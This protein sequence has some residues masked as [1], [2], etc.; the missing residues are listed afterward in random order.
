[1]S[2]GEIQR[3]LRR[4][5]A[6]PETIGP[7]ATD[8][9]TLRFLNCLRDAT[10]NPEQVGPADIAALTSQILRREALLQHNEHLEL[11]VPNPRHAS[12]PDQAQWVSFGLDVLGENK[13]SVRLR[14][15][16]WNPEWLGHD[17]FSADPC[18]LGER[19]APAPST[20]PADPSIVLDLGIRDY[21]SPGQAAA[22]R[23]S[24]LLP[25]GETLVVN[26]PTGSGKSLLFQAAAIRAARRSELTVI[27]VPTTALAKDQEF[28]LR[29]ILARVLPGQSL[30]NLAYHSGLSAEIREDIRQR[31]RQRQQS[32]VITSPE[33]VDQSLRIVI[34]RAANQGW[35]A[36]FALDEAHMLSQWGGYFRP[37]FQL[38]ATYVRHWR[39]LAPQ[40]SR[41]R[42]LLLSATLTDDT[43]ETIRALFEGPPGAEDS[44]PVHVFSVPELRAEPDYFVAEPAEETKRDARVQ[45]A[46]RH[47]PRPMII[48]TTKREPAKQLYTR[49]REA[50]FRRI[51]LFRGGDAATRE[52]EQ[53]LR[54]WR[55]GRL[56][57]VVATSAFG[58]GMDN[59]D[60]RTVVHA[61][62]PE[63]I[64][65]F[66]Q[67]VGR[68]GRDGRA[69]LSLW[70]P[71]YGDE[72]TA[73]SLAK[74]NELII[75]ADI[76]WD[77][78][79]TMR[80]SGEVQGDLS[81]KVELDAVRPSL[82]KKNQENY[83]WNVRVLLLMA[84]AGLIS[85]SVVPWSGVPDDDSTVSEYT[86]EERLEKAFRDTYGYIIVKESGE[87]TRDDWESKTD[88]IRQQTS[89]RLHQSRA[90]VQDLLKGKRP[91]NEVFADTYSLNLDGTVRK[92]A[93]RHERCPATRGKPMLESR[94]GR[95]V[96]S[97][98]LIASLMDNELPD[99]RFLVKGIECIHYPG[100]PGGK[101]EMRT[102][103][104]DMKRCLAYF[105]ARGFVELVL[106]DPWREEMDMQKL[107][108]HCP[109]GFIAVRSLHD[110]QEARKCFD[111]CLPLAR[112]TCL[113]E[114]ATIDDFRECEDESTDQ[115]HIILFPARLADPDRPGHRL[116]EVKQC[117][118]INEVRSNL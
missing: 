37:E 68:G 39:S 33:A 34:E 81:L 97:N 13:K 85:T 117:L 8:P 83:L 70:L 27:I 5:P 76:G 66:Y 102:W 91:F 12:W 52:G 36:C 65:R 18:I 99:S 100:R 14:A 86:D 95:P 26:L 41:L 84:R 46:A 67:E 48:Y 22:I 38:L 63:S 2:F 4:W 109:S 73:R 50:G 69:C 75:S 98:S 55:D 51:A 108:Q 116:L 79:R 43:L 54:N 57:I 15:R 78:W 106:P 90:A 87:G 82:H 40:G 11:E 21:R 64:D 9:L 61:C 105:I 20:I 114:D 44:S 45:E 93:V 24:A 28:R 6:P 74:K 3:A 113:G 16:A 89:E 77:R 10:E 25:E 31:I 96:F 49:L 19:R 111:P 101:L 17:N 72:K 32:I 88:R 110:I 60:V 62:E 71:A 1:M 118:G 7:D 94:H 56:D 58:L 35:L 47:A 30:F 103:T 92:P 104:Q 59:A 42:S 29:E 23:A 80:D 112:L 53:S 107:L 115:P